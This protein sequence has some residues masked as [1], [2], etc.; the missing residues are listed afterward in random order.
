MRHCSSL[1]VGSP[2]A[3]VKMPP[4]TENRSPPVQ[5]RPPVE[6]RPAVEPRFVPPPS[7]IAPR[8][9]PMPPAVAP[10]AAP[11]P[12][13]RK[14]PPVIPSKQPSSMQS[15]TGKHLSF[16]IEQRHKA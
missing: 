7:A 8:A 2:P 15:H 3:Q 14:D 9:A 10:R 12:P 4:K 16:F 13:A 6:N 5:N 1:I 11:S